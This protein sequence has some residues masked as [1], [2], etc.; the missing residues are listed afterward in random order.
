MA[1]TR[2]RRQEYLRG[3]RPENSQAQVNIRTHYYMA[4]SGAGASQMK[5][6]SNN[7]NMQKAK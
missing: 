6:S 5:K 1:N 3:I 4:I 7:Y 2:T